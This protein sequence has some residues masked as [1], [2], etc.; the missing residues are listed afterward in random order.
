M[1]E[2]INSGLT[3][4][5][6]FPPSVNSMYRAFRRGNICTTIMSK[7]GRE[8]VEDV[9]NRVQVSAPLTVRL[10]VRIDLYPPDNRR[11]DIDNYTKCVLDS[12]TKC[13]VWE[14]DSQIDK[15][16]IIRGTNQN[17]C[18]ISIFEINHAK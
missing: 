6:P 1:A 17:K 9:R 4:E 10:E 18:M 11:R 8:Y 12:L 2:V 3:F 16:T 14:D 13:G 15:L 5:L 7:K